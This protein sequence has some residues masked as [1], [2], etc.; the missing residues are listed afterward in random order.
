MFDISKLTIVTTLPFTNSKAQNDRNSSMENDHV[1]RSISSNRTN[2]RKFRTNFKLFFWFI[3]CIIGSILQVIEVSNIYFSYKITTLVT[4][5]YPPLITRPSLTVCFYTVEIYDWDKVNLSDLVEL[6]KIGL[7][8]ATQI[9]VSKEILKKVQTQVRNDGFGEM[10]DYTGIVNSNSTASQVMS[11]SLNF[12]TLIKGCY[13][14][15]N[16]DYMYHSDKK[17]SNFKETTYVRE[18]QKC[19]RIDSLLRSQEYKYML[20]NQIVSQGFFYQFKV[21]GKYSGRISNVMYS[22][23]PVGGFLRNGYIRQVMKETLSVSIILTYSIYRSQLLPE[24]FETACINY[25]NYLNKEHFVLKNFKHPKP[26][27]DDYRNYKYN[28]D[29]KSILHRGD[30]W[31]ECVKINSVKYFG[32]ISPGVSVTSDIEIPMMS[33]FELED[34]K[35]IFN[36]DRE[37]KTK[38]NDKCKWQECDSS[39]FIPQIVSSKVREVEGTKAQKV[40]VHVMTQP[41][42]HTVAVQKMNFVEYI[43]YIATAIGFWLGLTVYDSGLAF[44]RKAFPFIQSQMKNLMLHHNFLNKHHHH[45]HRH[46]RRRNN[47]HHKHHQPHVKSSTIESILTSTSATRFCARNPN[48]QLHRQRLTGILDYN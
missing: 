40:I 22:F 31:E 14:I 24:P 46:N 23:G 6:E 44:V 4:M 2:S 34:D 30:C 43:S 38:C 21:N 26:K 17:C 33:Q 10:I 41:V 20:L 32:K 12:T 8:N 28:F 36:F 47:D 13:E 29:P 16:I 45:H 42:T 11:R 37:I 1:N 18:M 19:I 35:N 9:M 48:I 3:I 5:S 39:Y 27:V 25:K 7:I 15:S